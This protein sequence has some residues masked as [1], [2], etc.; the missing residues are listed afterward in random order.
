MTLVIDE[1]QDLTPH[2]ALAPYRE[3][4]AAGAIGPDPI[5]GTEPVSRMPIYAYSADLECEH[6]EVPAKPCEHGCHA[7]KP[8]WRPA[9]L[10]PRKEAPDLMEAMKH[11]RRPKR[12]RSEPPTLLDSVV[13]DLDAEIDR[14]TKLR[15]EVLK[16][17]RAPA[18]SFR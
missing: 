10:P 15:D 13:S 18:D 7:P 5:E 11:K 17:Q 14:L 2:A 4:I 8:V 6:G 1:A 3:W 9:W 12:R 16:I